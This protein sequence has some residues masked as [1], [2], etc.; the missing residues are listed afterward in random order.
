MLYNAGFDFGCVIF[1]ILSEFI[2][3]QIGWKI[4]FIVKL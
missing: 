3:M 2:N 4:N 1:I